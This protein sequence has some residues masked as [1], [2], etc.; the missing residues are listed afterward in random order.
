M[1]NLKRMQDALT[2]PNQQIPVLLPII[3]VPEQK[4]PAA[5]PVKQK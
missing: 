5:T 1:I 2:Y 3:I 4:T